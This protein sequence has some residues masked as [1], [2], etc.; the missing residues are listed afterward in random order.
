MER[1]D[2]SVT[3]L[4]LGVYNLYDAVFSAQEVLNR[5]SILWKRDT[6]TSEI[7]AQYR[8]TRTRVS[9]RW[10]FPALPC[11]HKNVEC[12][13]F[14]SFFCISCFILSLRL[15]GKAHY[16]LKSGWRCCNR[17]SIISTRIDA[18]CLKAVCS[19]IGNSV[20]SKSQ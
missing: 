2:Y 20:W 14:H 5:K 13:T 8:C 12:A 7:N 1:E 10:I 19:K 11:N 15:K 9:E 4:W 6:K 18:K 17:V 16:H 3:T